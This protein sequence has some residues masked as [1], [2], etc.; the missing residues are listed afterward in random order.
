MNYERL[1]GARQFKDGIKYVDYYVGANT[2]LL[3]VNKTVLIG[4]YSSLGAARE[5]VSGLLTQ[6]G[7]VMDADRPLNEKITYLDSYT[8]QNSQSGNVANTFFATT[9]PAAG[10]GVIDLT[11]P[12]YIKIATDVAGT[13]YSRARLINE[14][15]A[16]GAVDP[17]SWSCRNFKTS[18]LTVSAQVEAFTLA[19]W[20][21]NSTVV[22]F[23]GSH[24]GP[25]F[26]GTGLTVE[27]GCVFRPNS[28]G[29]WRCSWYIQTSTEDTNTLYV[30]R[31]YRDT[32][33]SIFNRSDMSIVVDNYGSEVTWVLNE[34]PVFFLRASDYRLISEARPDPV[35]TVIYSSSTDELSADNVNPTFRAY[36]GTEIRRR[37]ATSPQ[38]SI[39]IYNSILKTIA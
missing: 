37:L 18:I 39:R 14:A 20:N 26:T 1:G 5:V 24:N 8:T 6:N 31:A 7:S 4:R 17:T 34:N 36:A 22:G 10:A 9:P 32:E 27:K 11:N 25:T 3:K 15:D 19:N 21:I 2:T 30:E 16:F 38:D 12:S 23:S 13:L 28:A 35:S 29:K 33:V